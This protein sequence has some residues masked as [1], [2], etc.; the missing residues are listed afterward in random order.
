MRSKRGRRLHLCGGDGSR[1]LILAGTKMHDECEDERAGESSTAS[2]ED[3]WEREPAAARCFGYW[4]GGESRVG[5]LGEED[6]LP[7]IRA[8]R[9]MRERGETLVLGQSVFGERAELVGREV[10]AGLEIVGH[11]L[12]MLGISLLIRE[13]R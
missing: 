5:L 11:G 6:D 7:A 12:W 8:G 13:R 9:K 1:W 3:L 10:K 2:N 4:C